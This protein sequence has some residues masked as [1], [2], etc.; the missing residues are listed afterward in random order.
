MAVV[1]AKAI[2]FVNFIISPPAG[3]EGAYSPA[4]AVRCGHCAWQGIVLGLAARCCT[5]SLM[6]IK[7]EK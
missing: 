2:N 7:A 5:V 3:F 6:Q 1:A 4:P